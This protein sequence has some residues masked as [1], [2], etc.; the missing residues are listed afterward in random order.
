ME[1][2]N[3]KEVLNP[4]HTQQLLV[5]NNSPQGL[6]ILEGYHMLVEADLVDKVADSSSYRLPLMVCL[7]KV[8]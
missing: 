4:S 1:V 6:E 5:L 2:H 3:S 7:N 8:K